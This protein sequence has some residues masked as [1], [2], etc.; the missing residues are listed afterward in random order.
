MVAAEDAAAASKK[1]G[2]AKN[3]DDGLVGATAEDAA[4]EPKPATT[5]AIPIAERPARRATSTVVTSDAF[6]SAIIIPV[7]AIV[8]GSGGLCLDAACI[9]GVA[10]VVE[11]SHPL[12][13][14]LSVTSR[15]VVAVDGESVPS[16]PLRLRPQ[17]LRAVLR[18][19][20]RRGHHKRVREG[21]EKVRGGV[22]NQRTCD[23]G[24]SS[25]GAVAATITAKDSHRRREKR[26]NLRKALRYGDGSG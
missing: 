14:A 23:G 19:M 7:T 12:A 4:A 2:A 6:V 18:Q 26:A 5:A 11:V 21:L 3:A 16:T 8:P 17:R 10:V 22:D 1:R 20:L 9:V 24:R 15:Q 13:H 25:C